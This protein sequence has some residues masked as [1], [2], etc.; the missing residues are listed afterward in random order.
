MLC[1][2]VDEYKVSGQEVKVVSSCSNS[3][4][5]LILIKR[6]ATV[7][8]VYFLTIQRLL[9]FTYLNFATRP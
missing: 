1:T 3:I 6:N 4:F 9:S 2:A 5:E 8:H 7:L